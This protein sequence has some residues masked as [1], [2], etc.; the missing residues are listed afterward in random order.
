MNHTRLLIVDDN[1]DGADTLGIA[2]R[3]SG[4]DV[5][6]AYD[7]PSALSLATARPPHIALIDLGLPVMDGIELARRLRALRA[8]TTLVAITGYAQREDQ[9]RTRAAGFAQ[10]LRKPVDLGELFAL[11]DALGAGAHRD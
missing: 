11:L 6:V 9:E 10:H 5:D 4:F 8:D 3:A 7:G 1:E 2:L